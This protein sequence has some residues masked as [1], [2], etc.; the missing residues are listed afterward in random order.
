MVG[1]ASLL[2]LLVFAVCFQNG[3]FQ[4]CS[5]QA[6]PSAAKST[7]NDTSWNEYLDSVYGSDRPPLRKDEIDFLYKSTP[8]KIRVRDWNHQRLL[9]V[10]QESWGDTYYHYSSKQYDDH[11]WAE[12]TRYST[13][14][15]NTYRDQSIVWEEGYSRGF[16]GRSKNNETKVG[17]GCWFNVARGSG[18]FVNVG[19]TL[20][21]PDKYSSTLFEDLG[22]TPKGCL[23]T[24]TTGDKCYDRYICTAAT[25]KGFDSI[26]VLSHSEL[27]ICGGQCATE[28]VTGA[29]PPVELRSGFRADRS[30]GCNEQ[31]RI[32]N[33][34]SLPESRPLLSFQL[35]P[36][37]AD[38][39]IPKAAPSSD[40]PYRR[41]ACVSRTQA[42]PF[43]GDFE[44][45][46]GI[47]SGV[48]S[49]P[50]MASR[51]A[52]VMESLSLNSG[53]WLLIDTGV[54]RASTMPPDDEMDDKRTQ[55]RHDRPHPA[56]PSS[57]CLRV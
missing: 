40:E 31:H 17:Y 15:L 7:F 49:H 27:I 28:S 48:A 30:C 33:C 55:D 38:T 56:T 9:G 14:Y 24:D 42:V 6:A 3:S 13:S 43:D 19:R 39:F 12:V 52:R 1:S 20:V 46:F 11:E 41:T 35:P 18:I 23:T 50:G 45:T 16:P 5:K 54:S 34:G 51:A 22:L 47:T 10:L 44:L 25:T 21:T 32:L 2:S 4:N 26:Q 53:P 57:D 29:C 37:S 36:A 8:I